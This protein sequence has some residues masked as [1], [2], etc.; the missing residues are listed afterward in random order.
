LAVAVEPVAP[1]SPAVHLYDRFMLDRRLRAVPVVNGPFPVG[2]VNRS[3]FLA[4]FGGLYR[5][6]TGA[7]QTVEPF[8]DAAPL[9]VDEA[10]PLDE[11]ADLIVEDGANYIYD[12]FIVTRRGE[13]LGVGSGYSLMRA[14]TERRQF[15]LH[16][17]AYHDG[18]TDLPNRPLFDDR[19]AFAIAAA[20]RARGRLAVMFVDLD[21][22]TGINDR[23]GAAVGDELL[24]RVGSRLRQAVR[25]GDT[26]ARLGSDEFGILLPAIAHAE[27][28]RLVGRKIVESFDPPFRVDGGDIYLSC[29]IG[30][31]VFPDDGAAARRL[32]RCAQRAAQH[33]KQVRNTFEWYR[34]GFGEDEPSSVCTYGTL[35]KAI[36]ERSLAL[37]YQPQVDLAT[38][39]VCGVEALVRWPQA[40]GPTVPANE[41]IAV[42]ESSGL[43]VPLAE[44]VLTTACRQMRAWHD[45]GVFVV[46]MAVNVSGV[47]LRQHGLAA[48]VERTL[49]ETGVPAAALELE[50]TEGAIA[51]DEAAVASA[52]GE[53][54]ALGV[55]VSIDDFGTGYSSLGR[56]VQVPVDSLK[57]DRAFVTP[58]GS[59]ERAA[60]LA[61]AVIAMAH[62]L[63][64]KVIAEGVETAEQLG[65]LRAQGCDVVQGFYFS[66]PVPADELAALVIDGR[67]LVHPAA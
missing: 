22:F 57:L 23:H 38:G 32:M 67:F 44:W 12:G 62:R 30:I 40:D 36:E 17:L 6:S 19:L 56:L 66:R 63:G 5:T 9:R 65:V 1:D 34:E 60:L 28:A 53:L 47:Q 37:A 29:S 51:Q 33:A 18:L 54:K 43:I 13:Y 59:D 41:I 8:M 24:K 64:L 7:T 21:Q 48:I 50:L 35:R 46:R 3:R 55:R 14:L 15:H 58:L 61:A 26:I 52:I 4:A 25:R 49:E 45:Q 11:L 16:H 20:E 10:L 39:R 27:A 31:S 42:A 2:L